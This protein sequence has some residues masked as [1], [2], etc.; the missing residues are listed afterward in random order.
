ML[1]RD[2]L[3]L[4]ASRLVQ[5]M[6]PLMCFTPAKW[7]SLNEACLY[8]GGM[9]RETMSKLIDEGYVYAKRINGTGSKIIVDRE[10]I[11][12]FLNDGRLN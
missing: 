11:D 9:S 6:K 4:L 3:D 10:T 2:E 1:N 5:M 12:K 8:A 7:M